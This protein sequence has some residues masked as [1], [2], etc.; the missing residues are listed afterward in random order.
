MESSALMAFASCPGR[1][2]HQFRI[3]S[4]FSCL[5]RA[6]DFGSTMVLVLVIYEAIASFRISTWGPPLV[7]WW[8]KKMDRSGCTRCMVQALPD[9]FVMPRTE[10][11]GASARRTAF[12]FRERIPSFW[13]EPEGFGWGA[14]R[15]WSTGKPEY[16]KST[17]LRRSGQTPD[18]KAFLV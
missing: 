2:R 4:T 15:V 10:R 13:M 11:C 14:T 7:P 6:E 5:R 17:N 3:T 1:L 9:R 12:R 18:K 8:K 16:R